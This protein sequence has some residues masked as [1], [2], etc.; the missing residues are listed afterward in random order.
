MRL[1]FDANLSPSL[2]ER[3][4][5]VYPDSVHVQL[6]GLQLSD[7]AVWQIA[8]DHGLTLVS[9]DTDFQAMALVKGFPPKLVLVRLGNCRTALVEAILRQRLLDVERFVTDSLEAILVLP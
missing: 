5:D 6:Y 9:K 1:L 8:A 7:V 2:V 4:A 3:L